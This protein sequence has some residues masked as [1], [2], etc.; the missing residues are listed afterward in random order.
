VPAAPSADTAGISA[1]PSAGATPVQPPAAAGDGTPA[2]VQQQRAFGGVATP[3]TTPKLGARGGAAAPADAVTPTAAG[4]AAAAAASLFSTPD[5]PA[6][7]SP[8]SAN[9]AKAAALAAAVAAAH[10]GPGFGSPASA[11]ES[12]LE[13]GRGGGSPTLAL[14]DVGNATLSTLSGPQFM[15]Q[16]QA[17]QQPAHVQQF[18]VEVGCR[19]LGLAP[20]GVAFA[21]LGGIISCIPAPP[22]SSGA[23]CPLS[24]PIGSPLPPSPPRRPSTCWTAARRRPRPSTTRAWRARRLCRHARRLRLPHSAGIS[25]G[26]PPL[27]C[28]QNAAKSKACPDSRPPRYCPNPQAAAVNV[29]AARHAPLIDSSP[30][31]L[32]DMDTMV[33]R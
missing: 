7:S 27:Q 12:P 11:F 3:G 28:T 14:C 21:V 4:A 23:S 6:A 30:F 13:A 33:F 24:C 19:R 32:G 10:G 8:H 25:T 20:T 22:A 5:G 17:A 9:A 2:S 31:D 16:V 18:K 15:A 26:A 1:V 29:D